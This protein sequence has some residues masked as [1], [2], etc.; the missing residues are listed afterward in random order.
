VLFGFSD[1]EDEK[2]MVFGNIVNYLAIDMMLLSRRL[3]FANDFSSSLC[4]CPLAM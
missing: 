3:A 2:T 4:F 1:P